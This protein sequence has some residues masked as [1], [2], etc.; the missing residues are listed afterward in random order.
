MTWRSPTGRW[1]LEHFAALLRH[2]KASSE[3]RS[4]RG[5]AQAHDQFRVDRGQFS[6]KPWPAGLDVRHLWRGVDAALSPLGETKV[7][8]GVRDINVADRHTGLG[9]C[10][11]QQLA[12]RPDERDPLSVLGIAGLLAD[13]QHR[14]S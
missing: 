3:Q 12:G 1:Q 7:L 10:T 13:E 9:K 2:P 8:H 14:R 11:L 5:R 4:G 6:F